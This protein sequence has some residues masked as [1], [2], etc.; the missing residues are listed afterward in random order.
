MAEERNCPIH[1]DACKPATQAEPGV[2]I[3]D[4]KPSEPAPSTVT[5]V[6]DRTPEERKELDDLEAEVRARVAAAEANDDGGA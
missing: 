5:I 6:N 1:G 4:L 3:D 2:I